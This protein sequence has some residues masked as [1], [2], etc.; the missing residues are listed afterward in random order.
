MG[1]VGEGGGGGEGGGAGTMSGSRDRK[2]KL[3][4]VSKSALLQFPK[5]KGQAECT[6]G[7]Q[8]MAVRPVWPTVLPQMYVCGIFNVRTN[9]GACRTREGGGGGGQAQISLHKS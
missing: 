5:K 4:H 7:P 9:L 3:R 6:R 2:T 8:M 1:N